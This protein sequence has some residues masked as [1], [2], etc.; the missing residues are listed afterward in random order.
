[1]NAAG[2]FSTWQP[3]YAAHGIATFPLKADK[4]PAMTRYDKLG[5]EGSTAIVGKQ[6]FARHG[7]LGFMTNARNRVAVLDVDTTAER[8]LTDALDR[9]GATPIVVRTASGKWHAWYRHNG[10]RRRIRPFGDTPIDLLGHGGFVVAPPSEAG[11]GSYNL[12]SGSLDDI[13]RLPVMRGLSPDMYKSVPAAQPLPGETIREG[14]RNDSLFAYCMRQV[15]HCDDMEALLDVTR[16]RNSEFMPPLPD[17]EVIEV[18]KS[19]SRTAGTDSAA[20]APGF[21]HPK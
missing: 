9:H 16:M 4:T 2:I 6:Q 18:A 10:E 3:E 1:M 11:R 15:R 7:A 12:I 8:V 17:A 14:H 21:P 20:P 5:I 19:T 13:D